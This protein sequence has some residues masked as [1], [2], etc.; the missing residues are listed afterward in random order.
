MRYRWLLVALLAIPLLQSA[1]QEPSTHHRTQ[2]KTQPSEK[3]KTPA[4]IAALAK[5]SVAVIVA[6]DESTAK[7]GTGFFVNDTGLMITN[8]HVVQGSALVGVRLPDTKRIVFAKT[9]RDWDADNDLVALQLGVVGSRPLLLG[10]S[11]KAFIGEPVTVVS[12]P[13]G[14]EQTVSD[15]LISAL[16]EFSGRKLLQITAPISSGS[17]G[18]PVFDKSGKVIGVVVSRLPEGQNLNFAIPINLVK[19]LLDS[20]REVKLDA[21]PKPHA[22]PHSESGSNEASRAQSEQDAAAQVMR[23]IADS[24]RQCPQC[25]QITAVRGKLCVFGVSDWL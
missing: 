22:Q 25:N 20:T 23:Q 5:D 18:G 14:L 9:V 1:G 13:E 8:L 6:A 3:D 4:E 10:N 15:G 21:I 17:S 2:K 24:I 19:P 12:N 16:R 7:L 11:D